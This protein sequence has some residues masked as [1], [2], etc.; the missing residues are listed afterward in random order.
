MACMLCAAYPTS[1]TGPREVAAAL[2]IWLLGRS[3]RTCNAMHTV[4]QKRGPKA[5]TW[6][7]LQPAVLDTSCA[8]V[9]E[10]RGSFKK[11]C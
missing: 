6:V 11:A 8:L 1:T 10:V 4:L 2:R 9:G 7:T 5:P 3:M